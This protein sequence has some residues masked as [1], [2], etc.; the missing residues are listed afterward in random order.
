MGTAL[1]VAVEKG[2][3]SKCGMTDVIGYFEALHFSAAGRET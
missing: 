2:G 1:L 3:V